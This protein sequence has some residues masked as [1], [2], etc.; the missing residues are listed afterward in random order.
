MK[1]VL[2]VLLI[3]VLFFGCKDVPLQDVTNA[4]LELKLED[5]GNANTVILLSLNVD[6]VSLGSSIDEGESKIVNVTIGTHKITGVYTI[7]LI[8]IISTFPTPIDEDVYVPETG[9]T[10]M[11]N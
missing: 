4:N 2:L 8:D 7:Y 9:Y 3:A 5:D 1:K 11:Y 10:W 6:G